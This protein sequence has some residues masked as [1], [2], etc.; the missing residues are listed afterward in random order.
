MGTER[1]LDNN[2]R[3]TVSA[4]SQTLSIVVLLNSAK[5][6]AYPD[7]HN[8]FTTKQAILALQQFVM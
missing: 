4:G 1:L 5:S 3:C 2:L 7:C 8:P 6:G